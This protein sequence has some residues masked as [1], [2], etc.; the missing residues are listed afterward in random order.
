MLKKFLSARR[1]CSGKSL[2]A[3]AISARVEKHRWPLEKFA[4]LIEQV[5]AAG[6]FDVMILWAPGK[7]DNPTFP[8]DDEAAAILAGQFGEQILAYPAKQLKETIV[9]LSAAD[10]VVTLDTG[11]LHMSAALAK[12]TVALMRASNVPL[13]HPWQV[14]QA[15]VTTDGHVSE[16]EVSD[17]LAA[18]NSLAAR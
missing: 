15:L 13:W 10:M 7:R 3:I 4:V 8:G 18:I 2:L 11:S 5:L 12:P 16:I 9:A 1:R 17:V 14:P 6:Q